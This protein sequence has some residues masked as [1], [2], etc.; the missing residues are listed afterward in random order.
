MLNKLG[1]SLQKTTQKK[2]HRKSG[3]FFVFNT[4]YL[5]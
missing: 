2:L 4:D 5:L 3:A 1:F